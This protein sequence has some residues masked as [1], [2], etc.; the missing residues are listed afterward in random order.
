MSGRQNAEPRLRRATLRDVETIAGWHPVEPEQVRAWWDDPE[1]EPWVMVMPEGQL[2]A[3]GE[4]WL[5]P[6]EDEVELARLIV[7]PELRGRGLGK[8]LTKVL[9]AT[10]ATKGLAVI[11]LRV[12]PDNEVA[13]GC[14]HASGFQ[15]LGP[16][17]SAIW[18]KDQPREWMWMTMPEAP[19]TAT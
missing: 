17:E 14:Y 12:A 18:N 1:V 7:A 4:L 3:Y 2:L 8:A 19:R 11:M 13:I 9:T 5:D 16:E 6:A 10:A 15:R